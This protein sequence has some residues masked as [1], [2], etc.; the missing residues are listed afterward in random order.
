MGLLERTKTAA[1]CGYNRAPRKPAPPAPFESQQQHRTSAPFSLLLFHH[2]RSKHAAQLL[3]RT[4]LPHVHCKQRTPA[5][6]LLLLLLLLSSCLLLAGCWLQGVA[7]Q[8]AVTV[9]Q[10]WPV[11]AGIA[12]SCNVVCC[13]AAS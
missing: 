5:A 1:C 11:L 7:Q 4:Q 8:R 12:F 10:Y 2:P 3:L 6:C 9:V 13:S